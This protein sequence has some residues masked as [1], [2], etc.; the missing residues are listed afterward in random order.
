MP[1]SHFSTTDYISS[2]DNRRSGTTCW[3]M[4]AEVNK[5]QYGFST[6]RTEGGKGRAPLPGRRGGG[7]GSYA[8]PATA[9]HRSGVARLR[10]AV[11]YHAGRSFSCTAVERHFQRER[12]EGVARHPDRHRGQTDARRSGDGPRRQR[13]VR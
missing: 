7:G 1:D 13:T 12:G 5:A 4:Q 9:L 6:T 8:C 2:S 11:V 10:A 3:R